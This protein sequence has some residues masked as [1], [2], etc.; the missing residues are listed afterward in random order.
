MHKL[1]WLFLFAAFQPTSTISVATSRTIS[2]A[3]SPRRVLFLFVVYIH[4]RTHT[5][6]SHPHFPPPQPFVL[7]THST[8][9]SLVFMAEILSAMHENEGGNP[10]PLL[11]ICNIEVA[12]LRSMGD[13]PGA[14]APYVQKA[15]SKVL[16]MLNDNVKAYWMEQFPNMH[17]GMCVCVFAC[18][19]WC[20]VHTHT[21]KLTPSLLTNLS[22][23]V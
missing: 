21:H 8:H 13:F 23:I 5:P 22:K 1:F 18:G 17:K 15:V 19:W 6:A 16:P 10:L 12:K 9:K 11:E 7:H 20:A 2:V 14:M 4:A 3:T